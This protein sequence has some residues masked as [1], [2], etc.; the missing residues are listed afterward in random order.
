MSSQNP[1]DFYKATTLGDFERRAEMLLTD[2]ERGFLY[3]ALGQYEQLGLVDALAFR[4]ISTL[5]TPAKLDLLKDVRQF[6]EVH[7]RVEFDRLV[8]YQ[9]MAHPWKAADVKRMEL[10]RSSVDLRSTGAGGVDFICQILFTGFIVS[11]MI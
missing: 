2:A 3:A 1:L 9:R 6:V 7:Q 4:V 10:G 11:S 5:D 8:P